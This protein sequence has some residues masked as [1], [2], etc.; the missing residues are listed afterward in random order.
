MYNV[1]NFSLWCDFVERNFLES[2]FREL[3]DKD[4]VN[5]A[6]SNPSIFKSAFLT[7]SAY[8]NDRKKLKNLEVKEKE[9]LQHLEL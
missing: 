1:N 7:S 8:Q 5:G 6:T 3:L 9:I 4:I 2:E